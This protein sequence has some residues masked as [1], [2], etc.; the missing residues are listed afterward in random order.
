MYHAPASPELSPLKPSGSVASPG[1]FQSQPGSACGDSGDSPES[2]YSHESASAEIDDLLPAFDFEGLRQAQLARSESCGSVQ[3]TGVTSDEIYRYI[4]G[5]D[6]S[7]PKCAYSCTFPG[8]SKQFGR[9]ENIKSHVQAHLGDRQF[10]CDVC[11]KRFV[12]GHDLKRHAITHS[13]VNPFDCPCGKKFGRHDALTR[14]RQRGGCVGAV[15]GT[16]KREEKKR[17][18]PKKEGSAPATPKRKGKGSR[19][20]N[21]NGNSPVPLSM[22][23]SPIP[24]FDFN[25]FGSGALPTSPQRMIADIPLFA[26]EA[27]LNNAFAKYVAHDSRQTSPCPMTMPPLTTSFM[28]PPPP[29]PSTIISQLSSPSRLSHT[30]YTHSR[31][32]SH[33][34]LSS[35]FSDN[36]GNDAIFSDPAS[37]SFGYTSDFAGTTPGLSASSSPSMSHSHHFGRPASSGGFEKAMRSEMLIDEDDG[38]QFFDA[39]DETEEGHRRLSAV[40]EEPNGYDSLFGD[41]RIMKVEELGF[42]RDFGSYEE[43][44]GLFGLR[45]E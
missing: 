38:M 1:S 31:N 25:D 16:R 8:C 17:G 35:I 34:A 6:V 39:G 32:N 40:E 36:I 30:G 24:D 2:H 7:N 15:E 29:P 23:S 44:S 41:E 43:M 42:S 19:N 28:L 14:H 20:T 22:M 21:V 26:A 45:A 4:A 33:V 12:R 3:F 10:V 18:R 5:P 9:K 13:G 37:P 11:N 27:G